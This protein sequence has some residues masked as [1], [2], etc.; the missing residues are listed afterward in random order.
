MTITS[1]D[2]VTVRQL[3]D[4]DMRD[5]IA[6]LLGQVDMT[7]DELQ[8]KGD[9]FELDATE[10]HVLGDIEAMEWMLSRH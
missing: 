8:A 5:E 3:T 10:R 6:H 2:K 9:A 1:T 4:A 7:R